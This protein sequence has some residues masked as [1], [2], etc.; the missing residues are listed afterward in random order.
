MCQ[1]PCFKTKICVV[2]SVSMSIANVSV[3]SLIFNDPM[4]DLFL[5][6]PK[7]KWAF[8]VAFVQ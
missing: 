8:E 4:I 2:I 7:E 6:P 5:N 1:L 3:G